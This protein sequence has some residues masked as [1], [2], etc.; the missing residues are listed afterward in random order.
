[1]GWSHCRANF[2]AE[3]HWQ[4]GAAL[5]E[6]QLPAY[7]SHP[8][9]IQRND[10]GLV[11]DVLGDLFA[12]NKRCM[13]QEWCGP[14]VWGCLVHRWSFPYVGYLRQQ[15]VF[16][17]LSTQLFGLV[18]GCILDVGS[19]LQSPNQL[20]IFIYSYRLD[21]KSRLNVYIYISRVSLA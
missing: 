17:S 8:H 13:G 20:Y 18:K 1:M 10:D 15:G 11:A 3:P 7:F 19:I 5:Q 2:T 21:Y 14:C 4:T 6:T 16:C 12:I 9:R